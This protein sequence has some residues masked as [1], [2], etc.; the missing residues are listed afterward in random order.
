MCLW[1]CLSATLYFV[2]VYHLK[3]VVEKLKI[4]QFLL[5]MLKIF[6]CKKPRNRQMHQQ[7]DILYVYCWCYNH[8]ESFKTENMIKNIKKNNKNNKNIQQK[9]LKI[10]TLLSTDQKNT[11]HSTERSKTN[12]W[13]IGISKGPLCSDKRC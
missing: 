2:A 8:I 5:L 10:C 9:Q 12:F 4:L 3:D 1:I 6:E 11:H 13:K 7:N